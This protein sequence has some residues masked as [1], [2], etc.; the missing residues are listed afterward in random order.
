MKMLKREFM[1][2]RDYYKT[3]LEALFNN[4]KLLAPGLKLFYYTVLE[5]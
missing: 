4:F 2:C 3:I 1:I 5:F